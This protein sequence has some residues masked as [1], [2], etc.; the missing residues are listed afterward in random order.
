MFIRFN[1]GIYCDAVIPGAVGVQP[2]IAP[3]DVIWNLPSDLNP[4]K[5]IQEERQAT[6]PVT[7]QLLFNEDGS[8]Q[9]ETVSSTYT[10]MQNPSI[11]TP[12]D[13]AAVTISYEVVS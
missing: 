3:G 13:I 1:K 6:D 12:D 5:T 9:M 8:P 7:C 11:F 10:L 2:S 4:S